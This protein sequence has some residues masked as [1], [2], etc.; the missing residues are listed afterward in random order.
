MKKIVSF[1]C[2]LLLLLMCGCAEAKP[3]RPFAEDISAGDVVL[4]GNYEQDNVVSNGKE[5]IEWIVLEVDD[6]RAL[7]ISK[8]I[9][10]TYTY[11]NNE[12]AVT[13]E[14]CKLRPWLNST[15]LEEA[16][17]E[18]ERGFIVMSD[19]ETG[20]VHQKH[21]SSISGGF[22]YTAEPL[23]ACS[24]TDMIFILSMDE[25]MEYMPNEADRV[26]S[27][28]VYVDV[29]SAASFAWRTRTP[30]WQVGAQQIVC[31]DGSADNITASNKTNMGI[32]PA[33]WV[34]LGE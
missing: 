32:R 16:F 34:N 1:V 14:K 18:E 27:A 10:T 29:N 24:T 22:V 25:V 11:H 8:D 2:A 30:G 3:K 5:P 7:L 6:G 4:Y 13:W 31:D 33:M 21:N 17:S 26:S 28:T 19:V 20:S 9:L 23:P 15:F 12:S